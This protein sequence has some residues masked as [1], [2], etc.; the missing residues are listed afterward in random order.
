MT[1]AALFSMLKM[2]N[3]YEIIQ[4]AYLSPATCG[5]PRRVLAYGVLFNIFTEFSSAPW[6][7]IDELTLTK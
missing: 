2:K 3:L 5:A 4:D 7:G 6:Q 1:F